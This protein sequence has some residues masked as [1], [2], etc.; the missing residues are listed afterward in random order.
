MD[1]DNFC[2]PQCTDPLVIV[3]KSAL[4]LL[5]LD[6]RCSDSAKY[7]GL[8]DSPIDGVKLPRDYD[9]KNAIRFAYKV[10]GPGPYLMQ[11]Y[12]KLAPYYVEKDF[13]REYL[14]NVV[15]CG[16][17]E[18]CHQSRQLDL[19]NRARFESSLYNC[20]PMWFTLTYRPADLPPSGELRYEDVQRFFKRLRSRWARQKLPTDFRYLVA[21]EYGSRTGRPHYHVIL[22]NNPFRCSEFD[23]EDYARLRKDIF[24]C[25]SHADVQAFD[26]G[27][28]AGGCAAYV[29]KYAAKQYA[30]TV[31]LVKPFIRMS[32]GHG[33]IGRALLDRDA[34][35][36][37][38]HPAFQRYQ[39]L[40]PSDMKVHEVTF[41]SYMKGVFFPSPGRMVP[42]HQRASFNRLSEILTMMVRCRVLSFEDAYNFL[43]R[44]RPS[45]SVLPH[46]LSYV[47]CKEHFACPTFG[48]W[49]Q[50][51]TAAEVALLCDELSELCDVDERDLRIYYDYTARLVPRD[52]PLGHFG[53]KL[54]RL[55]S[56]DRVQKSKE[57]F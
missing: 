42:A 50:V 44:L 10:L 52:V 35:F 1:N 22:W 41:G 51:R 53:A 48:R 13:Q 49:F 26:F 7:L 33:G 55:R 15:K 5:S 8:P 21:G 57:L 17:C 56:N 40:D 29:T 6:G 9:F 11:D 2:V 45:P 37:H 25:W 27:E 3:N 18:F 34:S 39:W 30:D 43:D 46:R 16:H 31:H 32:T 24:E 47:E 14:F 36:Y 38:Q 12:V 4:R 20:P 19:V 23:I 28:C 54:S